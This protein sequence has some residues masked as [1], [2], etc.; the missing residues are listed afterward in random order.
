MLKGV[1]PR[2]TPNALLWLGEMGH[3]DTLAIVDRNYPAFSKSSRVVSVPGLDTV[4]ALEAIL[5]VFPLDDFETPCAFRMVPDDGAPPELHEDVA[6]MLAQSEGREVDVSPIDR[7]PFYE[8]A[9][10]SYAT[11]ATGE[12]RPYGCFLLVKGVL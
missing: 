5:T 7:F 9:E 3:G 10:R 11:F 4:S 12:T 8:M 2:L 6:K 1:D